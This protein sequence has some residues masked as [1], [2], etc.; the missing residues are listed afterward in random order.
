[1]S[2]RKCQLTIMNLKKRIQ[3]EMKGHEYNWNDKKKNV[4]E[5]H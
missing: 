4:N 2:I 3:N 1:M 5:M